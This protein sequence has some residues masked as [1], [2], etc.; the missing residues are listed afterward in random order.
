M[1]TSSPI[2][3]AASGPG[4]GEPDAARPQ[5]APSPWQDFWFAD[6]AQSPHASQ[7]PSAAAQQSARTIGIR[8]RRRMLG[9]VARIEAARQA[10]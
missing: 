5:R 1:A 7:P 8:R 4:R 6:H 10:R 9:I 3:A 2:G